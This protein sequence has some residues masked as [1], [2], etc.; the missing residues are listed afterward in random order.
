MLKIHIDT[1][2]LIVVSS[3]LSQFLFLVI[4]FL[5]SSNSSSNL[6]YFKKAG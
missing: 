4:L 1:E 6:D 3:I 2:H 5:K